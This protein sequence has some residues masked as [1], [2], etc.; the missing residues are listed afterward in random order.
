MEGVLLPIEFR[1]FLDLDHSFAMSIESTMSTP[2]PQPETFMEKAKRKIREEPLVTAGTDKRLLFLAFVTSGIL[3]PFPFVH[4]MWY[5]WASYLCCR[6]I[7]DMSR[8]LYGD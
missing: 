5:T 4:V 1:H 6:C 2:L 3:S 8:S 7:I